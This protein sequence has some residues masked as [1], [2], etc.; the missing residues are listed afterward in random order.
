MDFTENYF[1]GW[2]NLTALTLCLILHSVCL[3]SLVRSDTRS[4]GIF[5]RWLWCIFFTS[6]LWIMR[7][8]VVSGLNMHLNGGVLMALM[9]GWR[10]SVIGMS[11]VVLLTAYFNGVLLVNLGTSMVLNAILPATLGYLF[12]LLCEAKLPR[13]FFIYVYVSSFFGTWFSTIVSGTVIAGILALSQAMRWD[14][15]SND[16]LPFYYLLGFSEAFLSTAMITLFV[17]YK[18]EWVYSFRDSRYLKG[19]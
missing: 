8:S 5:N 7:A 16:F 2:L 1:P 9:F 6:L 13:H 4:E 18:P 3:Y 14:L 15:L 11:L 12:F 10:M 19:K 17:V